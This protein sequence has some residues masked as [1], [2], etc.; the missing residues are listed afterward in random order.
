MLLGA[1]RGFLAALLPLVRAARCPVVICLEQ[2]A[3]PAG[4]EALAMARVEMRAPGAS[5]LLR[6][7]ALVAAA[8]GVAPGAASLEQLQGI[9]AARVRG[10]VVLPCICVA[11]FACVPT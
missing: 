1:D 7:L 8:E 4:L 5:E 10:P 2:P 6:L 9:V 3:P 11:P